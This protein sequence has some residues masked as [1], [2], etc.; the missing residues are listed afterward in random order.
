M[1]SGA[2]TVR[3]K[4]DSFP[5]LIPGNGSQEEAVRLALDI[6]PFE[7]LLD[8]ALSPAEQ[9]RVS[10]NCRNPLR[11][12][13][14]R[15][16]VI[17][18]LEFHSESLRSSQIQLSN[19]LPELAPARSLHIPLIRRLVRELEYTDKSLSTDLIRGM[20]I[21]GVISQTSTLPAKET[22]ATMSLH[23]VKWQCERRMR[24]F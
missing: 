3:R 2:A 24:R 10:Y 21:V 13:R 16:R 19:S 23:D 9:A 22:P 12:K 11:A 7:R 8:N 4:G 6:N 1:D 14:H 17:E 15:R 18:H 5:C 20:P